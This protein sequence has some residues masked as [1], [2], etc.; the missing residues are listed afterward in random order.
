MAERKCWD[1]FLALYDWPY[2]AQTS[3][4]IMFGVQEIQCRSEG[5]RDFFFIIP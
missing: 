5:L 2:I 3:L 4:Q 1:K